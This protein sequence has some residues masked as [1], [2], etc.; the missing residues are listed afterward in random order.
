MRVVKYFRENRGTVR[1]RMSQH[2]NIAIAIICQ[3]IGAK[4]SNL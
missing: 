1:I 3:N 2:H 4:T